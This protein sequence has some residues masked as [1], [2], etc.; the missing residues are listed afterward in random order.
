MG[1]CSASLRLLNDG[2][3]NLLSRDCPRPFAPGGGGKEGLADW[4]GEGR[5]AFGG[6]ARGA[7]EDVDVDAGDCS[8]MPLTG[9]E[10]WLR[11]GL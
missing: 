2:S 6:K 9:R 1:V 7:G 11:G 3:P 5:R 10:C 8:N 4:S